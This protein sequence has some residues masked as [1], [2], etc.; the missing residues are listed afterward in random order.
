MTESFPTLTAPLSCTW[1]VFSIGV[2]AVAVVLL[3]CAFPYLSFPPCFL[4]QTVRGLMLFESAFN[5][6]NR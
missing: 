2:F 3:E 1:A 5:Q 6:L 4:F